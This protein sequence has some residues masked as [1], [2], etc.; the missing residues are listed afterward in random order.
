M[1]KLYAV[2]DKNSKATYAW[3]EEIARENENN[4]AIIKAA[5]SFM[6]AIQ[7]KND[8]LNSAE[9]IKRFMC[10]T[11]GIEWSDSFSH[12]KNEPFVAKVV[13]AKADT[14]DEVSM[15]VLEAFK[16]GVTAQQIAERMRE[17]SFSEQQIQKYLPELSKKI[18]FIS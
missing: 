12:Y 15:A 5:H 18:S 10:V 9:A 6:V 11:L 4:P 8:A 17:K 3:S 13:E 2:A 14:T 1:A 16:A 7:S